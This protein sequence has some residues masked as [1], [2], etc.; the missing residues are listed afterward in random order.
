MYLFIE[1]SNLF[2]SL[3]CHLNFVSN[4]RFF[5]STRPLFHIFFIFIILFLYFFFFSVL[6][7]LTSVSIPG[8]SFYATEGLGMMIES[9]VGMRPFRISHSS[10]PLPWPLGGSLQL[11]DSLSRAWGCHALP[12][13]SRDAFD[14]VRRDFASLS[15]GSRSALV[16][17]SS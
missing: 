16:S 12:L 15:P 13:R 10:E 2:K 9:G 5:P 17:Q 11:S 3:I 14:R 4:Q 7:V 6:L 1:I 8:E